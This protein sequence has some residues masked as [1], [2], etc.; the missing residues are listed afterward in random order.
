MILRFRPYKLQFRYP[1]AIAS[2][3][4]AT[5]EAVFVE[6]EYH[7][8]IGYGEAAMPPYVGENQESVLSFLSNLAL[9]QF[10][11]P[12][13]VDTILDYCD[14]TTSGN[15]A[16]K[17]AIDI[18]LHDL[19]GK[20]LRK[21]LYDW[22]E[23][24]HT[25]APHTSITIGMDTAENIVKK[26]QEAS[27]FKII[28]VKLGGQNDKQLVQTIRSLTNKPLMIDANQG[29]KDKQASLELVCWLHEQNVILIEQPFPKEMKDESAWLREHSPLPIIADESVQRLSDIEGIK[30]VFD[31]INIKLMKCTGLR[32]ARKMIEKARQ[33]N[34]KI[35]LGCM[36]ESSCAV[37]A[38]AHLSPLA[39]WADLDGPFLIQNDPF[40]GMTV[41]DGKIV[42][43][44]LTGI[45]V[46][47]TNF[48]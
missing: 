29:W 41:A 12:L 13:E 30:G 26:V 16:A 33:L 38:A 35:L 18:A 21:P 36:A 8:I 4:R 39:D 15:H 7:G 47:T 45:G 34:L 6:L 40:A 10:D 43:N 32:E 11:N 14:A 5:T 46:R 19:C 25:K 24:D 44:Q 27:Q 22:W 9:E 28:K 48:Y 20:I 23:I 17:A 37:T 42:L 1:F 2:G 3:V 31:G